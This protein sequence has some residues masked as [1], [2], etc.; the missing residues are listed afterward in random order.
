M[1]QT[2]LFNKKKQTQRQNKQTI[3][4]KAEREEEGI[5]TTIHKIEKQE[6][7]TVYHTELYSVSSNKP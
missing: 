6:D 7:P 3:V 2:N 5:Q 1:T 4:T